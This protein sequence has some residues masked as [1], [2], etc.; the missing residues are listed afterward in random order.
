MEEIGAL[1]Q[2]SLFPE[3][4]APRALPSPG[5]RIRRATPAPRLPALVAEYLAHLA[6]LGKARHTLDATARDLDQ[7]IAFLG[8]LPIDRLSTD[9]VRRFVQK[10]ATER[11]NSVTSLRRKIATLKMFT[12]YLRAHGYR[13]DDPAAVIPYPPAEERP[14]EP[15]SGAEVAELLATVRSPEHRLLVLLMLEAGLKREEVL[16]LRPADILLTG[17]REGY[18]TIRRGLA[19]KRVR[20]RTVPLTARLVEALRPALER[21]PPDRPLLELSTRGVDYIVRELGQRAGVPLGGTLT[22]QRLRDT[23]AV[24]WLRER[25]AAYGPLTSPLDEGLEARLERELAT[26]LGLSGVLAVDRY[27]RVARQ[28]QDRSEPFFLPSP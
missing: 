12:R 6:R 25:L 8:P 21:C 7:L 20:E 5:S 9:A 14:P 13:A 24:A 4:V 19:A 11:A 18:C 23:F 16:A 10:L 15:L 22:P 1:R 28:E 27:L 17:E 3:L 2:L 26:L